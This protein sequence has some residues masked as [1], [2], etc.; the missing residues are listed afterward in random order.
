MLPVTCLDPQDPE[1]VL[2]KFNLQDRLATPGNSSDVTVGRT[3]ATSI[4]LSE[5]CAK[6]AADRGRFLRTAFV[7]R[8]MF[9]IVN[10]LGEDG[11]LRYWGTSYGTALGATA[12]AMFPGRIDKIVL[13][14]VL[15]PYLWWQSY[16]ED[17]LIDFDMTFREFLSQ[18]VANPDPCP[19]SGNRRGKTAEDLL[20]K[21]KYDP[22][23]IP[24]SYM[25]LDY[26]FWTMVQ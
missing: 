6:I 7:T 19:L 22:I 25:L 9:Q 16:S 17:Q 26:G 8:D 3:W 14:G 15:N 13:D 18:C 11:L 21:V 24:D 12:I 5:A 10:A 2:K 1:Y 4:Q 20:V 23:P